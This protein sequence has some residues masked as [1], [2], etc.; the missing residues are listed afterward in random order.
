M[1]P[2]Q[3]DHRLT[4]DSPGAKWERDRWPRG[5]RRDSSAHAR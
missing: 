5:A 2:A 1:A 4:P 3:L